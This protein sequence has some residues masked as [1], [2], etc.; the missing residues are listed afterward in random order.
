[1]LKHQGPEDIKFLLPK[2]Q[3]TSLEGDMDLKRFHRIDD[4]PGLFVL[5]DVHNRHFYVELVDSFPE[6]ALT[7]KMGAN[8]FAD[9]DSSRDSQTIR[10]VASASPAWKSLIRE[11]TSRKFRTSLLFYFRTELTRVRGVEEVNRLNSGNTEVKVGFHLSRN[12]Y[13]LSPHT[14][15]G[16]KLV[17]IILY[18][19]TNEEDSLV[20]AGTNFY[21]PIEKVAGDQFLSKLL[22]KAGKLLPQ[23]T[24]EVFGV[25]LD[26]V[27]GTH[28]N[29]EQVA[30]ALE[31]FDRI[32]QRS[33]QL[34]YQ[35]N[36]AVAFVKSNYSWHDVRL[37]DVPPNFLR[38]SFYINFMIKPSGPPNAGKSFAS[39]LRFWER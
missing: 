1:M 23:G 26:R 19:A 22:S 31:E 37:V 25:S 12:G 29:H 35:P 39:W 24:S 18:M 14:D 33:S 10:E 4:T 20:E 5:D 6:V 9:F 11:V 28:D 38:K 7:H 3:R 32:H 30:V 36:R 13:V 8:Y 27:Y 2:P 17:T 34:G 15:T 16:A 21:C